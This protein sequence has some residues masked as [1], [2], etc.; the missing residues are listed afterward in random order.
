MTLLAEIIRVGRVIR[1]SA[2]YLGR[3][4][5]QHATFA[6]T[7]ALKVGERK[8][9][10]L[11]GVMRALQDNSQN[12]SPTLFQTAFSLA[13]KVALVTGANGG[14]GLEG[15]LAL[16]EAGA[17]AVYCVDIANTPGHEFTKVQ[18]FAARMHGGSAGRLEYVCADV[19]DQEK[20][21]KVGKTIGDKEGRMDVCFGAAGIAGES[22][23]SLYIPA[24]SMQQMLSVNLQGAL[25][26]AQA[27]GQQMTRFG[28]GGSIVMVASIVGSISMNIGLTSYEASKSGVQ[29]M[30]RS[31]ACE[32]APQGIR[33]N[34][35][36][37]GAFRTPM[38]NAM[39]EDA[40]EKAKAIA[41]MTALKR[42]GVPH[43]IRGAVVWL[44]SEASSFCT[45]SDIV[46]DGGHRA[47]GFC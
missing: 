38:V 35:I 9:A 10:I 7:S 18:E 20:M 47:G 42:M 31:L 44:A 17:R 15:A 46:V 2:V 40:P 14:L 22:L 28:N 21:W 19:S 16:A 8:P 24:A 23:E 3:G 4:G 39:F 5:L 26:T 33:V 34:T 27:A 41:D 1:P 13:D 37:P 45:G 12:P 30:A 29:Q 32:L 43:E 6:T 36:S 25:Y 11:H